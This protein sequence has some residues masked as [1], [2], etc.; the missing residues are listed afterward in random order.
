MED[1][2]TTLSRN[3]IYETLVADVL[4]DATETD[5]RL[6]LIPLSEMDSEQELGNENPEYLF[7]HEGSN[8][9]PD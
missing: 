9:C 8:E 7:P 2:G 5:W 4:K 3:E 1:L 6:F